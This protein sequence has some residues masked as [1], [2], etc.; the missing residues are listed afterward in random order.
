MRGY[1]LIA[2]IALA[3]CHPPAPPPSIAART[4]ADEGMRFTLTGR[5]TAIVSPQPGVGIWALR[6]GAPPSQRIAHFGVRSL[7]S[8]PEAWLRI[9]DSVTVWCALVGRDTLVDSMR[10][11]ERAP[12]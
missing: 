11:W 12:Q 3:S 4:A 8:G 1:R 5:T 9:G 10:A 2:V 6:V 7:G